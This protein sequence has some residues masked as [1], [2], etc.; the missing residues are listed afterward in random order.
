MSSTSTKKTQNTLEAHEKKSERF[1]PYD[2]IVSYEDITNSDLTSSEFRVYCAIL[3]YARKYGHL[4]ISNETFLKD[5]PVFGLRQFQDHCQSLEEKGFLCR[6]QHPLHKRGSMRYL[7]PKAYYDRF[8]SYI[9]KKYKHSRYAA[10]VKVYFEGGSIDEFAH[11]YSSQLNNPVALIKNPRIS[12]AIKSSTCGKPAPPTDMRKTRISINNI[13]I[14]KEKENSNRGNLLPFF[15][16]FGNKE[17]TKEWMEYISKKQSFDIL[18]L[19][20][21][22]ASNKEHYDQRDNP[23]GA[24]IDAMKGGYADEKIHKAQEKLAKE[25]QAIDERETKAKRRQVASQIA[26]AIQRHAK[27]HRVKSYYISHD[28]YHAQISFSITSTC[29]NF[30]YGDPKTIDRLLGFAKKN[31]IE[32]NLKEKKE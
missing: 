23:R 1:I 6:L 32:I 3:G 28:Q 25:K 11:A 30:D 26:Q 15:T 27:E 24:L 12:Y 31:D 7:I 17:I 10:Q 9:L 4:S 2:V 14:I 20:K 22:Y 8:I 29:C 19:K 18:K 13:N 21:L 5:N 16:D